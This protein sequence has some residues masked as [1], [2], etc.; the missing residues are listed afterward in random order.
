[1]KIIDQLHDNIETSK[2]D[3]LTAEQCASMA[4]QPPDYS[5][6]G[7]AIIISNPHKN[8]SES[9]YETIKKTII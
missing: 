6:L 8:T 3:E 9:F 5:K 2:I 7:S 1:M 4:S